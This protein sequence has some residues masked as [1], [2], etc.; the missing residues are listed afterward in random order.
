VLSNGLP[1][2]EKIKKKHM[3][4]KLK[5]ILP[6]LLASISVFGQTTLTLNT[7]IETVL[8]N[9]Y[10]IQIAKN[11]VEIATNNNTWGNA[12]FTPQVNFNANGSYANNNINQRFTNGTE[13]VKNGV[14][15]SNYG[16]GVSLSWALFNGMRAHYLYKQLGVVQDLNEVQLKS[17][18]NN[19]VGDVMAAY[20]NVLREQQTLKNLNENLGIFD[21][22]LKI[23][24]TRFIIGS[25]AKTD[26]LQAKIDL[27]EQKSLIIRQK[28]AVMVAKAQLN[29]ILAKDATE[30][31][32]VEEITP[33]LDSLNYDSLKRA[34]YQNNI[35]IITLNRNVDIATYQTKIARSAIYPSIMLNSAYNFN[36]SSSQAGFSLYNQSY[37]FTGGLTLGWNL[38]NGLNTKRII[39][40]TDIQLSTAQLQLKDLQTQVNNG[41]S[42]AWYNYTTA[43]E[44]YKLE[45][46]NEGL[47]KENVDIMLERFRLGNCTTIDL[48]L[49]QQTLQESQNRLIQ[50]GFQ[51]KLAETE[52]LRLSGG[53][54]K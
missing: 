5:Y 36:R 18:I 33:E 21:E 12:G 23:A 35:D 4:H 46:E 32:T 16:A 13:I 11:N 41:F 48:K 39:K 14:G 6:L 47:A 38:Y 44:Q 51:L 54:A 43:K 52:L 42:A 22:R 17:N 8:K 10:G 3:K 24:D 30:D 29:Q 7:A 1:T 37:G 31:F 15:S 40:N 2:A 25:A 19:S 27:N 49:A 20:F 34:L 28:G 9:N 53:L 45:K 50:A 26:L